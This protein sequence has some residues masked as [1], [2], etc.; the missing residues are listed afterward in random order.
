MQRIELDN[1]RV[2]SSH[3]GFDLAPVT[4]LTGKNNS[5]KSSLIKSFLVLA[6]YLEQEDQT[7]L[8]LD[9][10]R[11]SRHRI[12]DWENMVNWDSGQSENLKFSYVRNGIEVSYEFEYDGEGL[13]PHLYQFQLTVPGVDRL[14][15]RSISG[16]EGYQLDVSQKLI[17]YLTGG[18][19]IQRRILEAAS[20]PQKI[21]K[22]RQELQELEAAIDNSQHQ[23][24]PATEFYKLLQARQKAQTAIHNLE[25]LA[26]KA[27]SVAGIF[28]QAEVWVKEAGIKP[29]IAGLIRAALHSYVTENSATVE[30]EFPESEYDEAFD[31][32][33]SVLDEEE[34]VNEEA[35]E[36]AK[37]ERRRT[38]AER[39][40]ERRTLELSKEQSYRTLVRFSDVVLYH[41]KFPM[42][43][44]GANRT[45]QARLYLT[46]N[47][48]SDIS[49]IANDFHRLGM[50]AGGG[51]DTF[52]TKW[53]DNFGIGERAVTETVDNVA[54]RIG[55]V[56]NERYVNLADL[57]FGAGQILTV[58]L[59][60]ATLIQ[61]YELSGP[62][63]RITAKFNP[64]IVLIEE[65]EANL[66]PQFQSLLAE[67]FT[68][69]A[70]SDYGL[71][72]VLETHSEYLIRNIQVL[73]KAERGN[74]MKSRSVGD[75]RNEA[76]E[77]TAK[78]ALFKVYYLD[79]PS[80]ANGYKYGHEMRLRDDGAFLDKF[81][82]GF[83]DVARKLAFEVL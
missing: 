49:T 22:L 25:A 4:V 76:I 58:L 56:K 7:V 53:L 5:G 51:A 40:Q 18:A 44:L 26:T 52:L 61:E 29:T 67:M 62:E 41:I 57:G 69:L 75:D 31:D 3:A 11:A 32:I 43:H 66:H 71:Q 79:P 73:V 77:G 6:D 9:G 82:E 63:R 2:F 60:I 13:P 33:F 81:G 83:L 42:E 38:I 64:T 20:Y 8:R 35:L 36:M 37:E 68:S 45:H 24:D 1:F 80:E 55:V 27:G 19:E 59:Q 50:F 65:P 70:Q 47:G 74:L 54:I 72:F 46:G 17:D 34:E 10:K 48:H 30:E 12:S 39:N 16:G 21:E 14:T 15:M 28:F 23:G 78:T